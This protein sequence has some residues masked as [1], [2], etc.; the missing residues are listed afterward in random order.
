MIRGLNHNNVYDLGSLVPEIATAAGGHAFQLLV[1]PG[2][3]SST[4]VFNPSTMVYEANEPKDSYSHGMDVIFNEVFQL[5][6]T[7]FDLRPLRSL[8]KNTH[9]FMTAEMIQT[10]HGYDALLI[11][12][13]SSAST[14]I[15]QNLT[16]TLQ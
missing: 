5:G 9:Q 10:I 15:N 14:N 11:M 13:G 4:A 7:L 6:Y 12:S 16:K 3:G 8:A 1:L 2:H